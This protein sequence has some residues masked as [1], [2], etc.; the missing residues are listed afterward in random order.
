[1]FY[2]WSNDATCPVSRFVNMHSITVKCEAIKPRWFIIHQTT[3]LDVF[4]LTFTI[5]WEHDWFAW[6]LKQTSWISASKWEHWSAVAEINCL[7]RIKS[8]V[9]FRSQVHTDNFS[10]SLVRMIHSNTMVQSYRIPSLWQLLQIAWIQNYEIE[11]EDHNNRDSP[12]NS[13]TWSSC[14]DLLETRWAIC[15]FISHGVK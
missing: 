9:M 14:M 8:A 7:L 13:A 4:R 5:P 12:R 15:S 10:D 6:N 3:K 2:L 1:M 11:E